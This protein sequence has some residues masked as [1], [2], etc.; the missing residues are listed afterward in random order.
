MRAA[1]D[2]GNL[3]PVFRSGQQLGKYRVLQPLGRGKPDGL[4][5]VEDEAHNRFALRSPIAD[6]ED[7]TGAIS[8]CARFRTDAESLRHIVHLNLVPLFDVVID[9]GYVCFV[10]ER[11][12]GRTLADQLGQGELAPP[13]ALYVTR[14]ILEGC[15]AAHAAGR[16]H[17]ELRPGKILLVPLEGWDLVKVADAGLSALRDDA[18]LEFGKGALTGTVRVP[19][20]TYMAPEQVR[21]RSVD[22]RTDLYAIGTMLFEMLA[23]RAP[24][25]GRDLEQVKVQQVSWPAPRLAEVAQGERWVTPELSALIDTALAKEREARFSSA[26]AM[27]EAVDAA[28]RS[29]S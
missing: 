11:V 21:E 23:G 3:R 16:L 2:R 1:R 7:D 5:E 19:L 20:A 29:I 27:I 8:V 22:A 24:F 25:P 14:K 4:Y 9:K 10:Y 13:I 26:A 6:L 28:L 15:A 18:V 17:G 12:R